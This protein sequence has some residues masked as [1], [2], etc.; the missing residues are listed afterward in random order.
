MRPG[1]GAN[2]SAKRRAEHTSKKGSVI[3]ISF[4]AFCVAVAS[5]F[6]RSTF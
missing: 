3:A 6:T 4:L 1:G 5:S 2:A